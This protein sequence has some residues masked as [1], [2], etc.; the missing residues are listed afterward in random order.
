MVMTVSCFVRS[1]ECAV[2]HASQ[3]IKNAQKET[4]LS[5]RSNSISEEELA[6]DRLRPDAPKSME[7]I[8]SC[9]KQK[10]DLFPYKE[11]VLES[12]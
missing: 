1:K 7:L 12:E 10:T 11:A 6:S 2:N 5:Y 8:A 9:S 4:N 3:E